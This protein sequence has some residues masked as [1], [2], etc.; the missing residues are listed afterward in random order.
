MAVLELSLTVCWLARACVRRVVC[1]FEPGVCHGRSRVA[2][3]E[4]GAGDAGLDRLGRHGRLS[5][6]MQGDRS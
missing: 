4:L 6:H 2:A 3:D 1:V 5:V